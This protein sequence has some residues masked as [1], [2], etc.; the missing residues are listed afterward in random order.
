MNLLISVSLSLSPLILRTW[1]RATWCMLFVRRLRCWR[2]RSRSCTR[3]TRCWN[4][5]TLCWS[6]WPTRI[7]STSWPT[8][9]PKAAAHHRRCSSNNNNWRLSQTA[10]PPWLTTRGVRASLISPTSPRRDPPSPETHAQ[11]HT[12]HR[13]EWILLEKTTTT[14]VPLAP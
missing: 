13:Q 7:S 10:P 2:S 9:S 14:T 1:W 8:S 5:R 3:G 4:A 12:S 6:R 11:T